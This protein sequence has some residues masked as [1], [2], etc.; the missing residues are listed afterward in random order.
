VPAGVIFLAATQKP[1][2]DTIPTYLRDLFAFGWG[3]RCTTPQMSDT[4]LGAGWST[5]GYTASTI[6]AAHRAWGICCTRAASRCACAPSPDRRRPDPARRRAEALRAAHAKPATLSLIDRD[7]DVRRR[8]PPQPPKGARPTDLASPP[9]GAEAA[10]MERGS[11]L[12]TIC[13]TINVWKTSRSGHSGTKTSGSWTGYAPIRRR[14]ANSSGSGS[15]TFAPG[16]AAGSK[17]G[18]SVPTPRF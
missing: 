11:A 15:G 7:Q 3:F 14:S 5:A 1:S 9:A 8:Q 18:S 17:T 12:F 6:D 13:R 10:V 16:V 2:G 4:I